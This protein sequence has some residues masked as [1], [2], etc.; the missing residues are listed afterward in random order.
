VYRE[1]NIFYWA[2]ALLKHTYDYI[3]SCIS[4]ASNPP[5]FQIPRLR[6]VDAGVLLAYSKDV[7]SLVKGRTVSAMYLAEE[8]IPIRAGEAFVKYIHNDKPNP[9]IFFNME[10][11]EVRVPGIYAT[12][13][14][15][16]NEQAH[17]HLRL[18]GWV[19]IVLQW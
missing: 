1:A 11:D 17:I 4:V 13:S 15:H 3:D 19:L 14:I 6:F 7:T 12:C 10:L 16:Y 8:L 5:P 2:K 18:S 9:N